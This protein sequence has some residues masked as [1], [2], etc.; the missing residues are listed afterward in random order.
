MRFLTKNEQKQVDKNYKE[1][2]IDVMKITGT[3]TV[4]LSLICVLQQGEMGFITGKIV[5]Y[6]LTLASLP[7]TTIC[8]GFLLAIGG[9]LL[10][11]Q[12]VEDYLENNFKKQQTQTEVEKEALKILTS[13]KT[14]HM[15]ATKNNKDDE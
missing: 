12:L 11:S 15:L 1:T 13:L 3:T 10:V 5:T 8:G 2:E 4:G 6:F 14:S 9:G 7:S